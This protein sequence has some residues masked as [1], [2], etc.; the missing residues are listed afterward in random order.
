MDTLRHC[1]AILTFNSKSKTGIISMED[2]DD[3]FWD[4]QV[5]ILEHYQ[6]RAQK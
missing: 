5:P 1:E 4:L 6:E 3:I 2:D